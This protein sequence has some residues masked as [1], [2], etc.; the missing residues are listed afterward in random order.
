[1]LLFDAINNV[2]LVC[3]IAGIAMQA[4]VLYLR[5][6]P[7]REIL[8]VIAAITPATFFAATAFTRFLSWD[9]SYIFYDIVNFY[10][11]RLQQWEFGSFRTSI[12]LFGPLFA[13]LQAGMPLTKDVVLVA[14]KA[15][16]WLL[17]VAIITIITDQLH[18]LFFPKIKKCLF[19]G[20]VYTAILSL[21]V[22]GLALKTLNYDLFSMLFGVLGCIWCMAGL[23]PDRKNLLVAAL[24]TLTLAAQEKLIASPLLWVALV[25]TTVR[26]AGASNL[27]L[28]KLV[29]QTG[30][31]A[32]A[33]TAIPMVTIAA[34]FAIVYCTHGPSG[35]A[36]NADQLFISWM[37]CFWPFIRLFGADT[38]PSVVNQSLF[39]ELPGILARTAIVVVSV[40]LL[41]LF[42]TTLQQ[43]FRS[44]KRYRSWA[45]SVASITNYLQLVLLTIITVTGVVAQ[46]ALTVYIWP[47]VPVTTG[48]YVPRMTFNGIAHHFGAGSFLEHTAASMAWSCAVFVNALP[49]IL[50][51]GL[52]AASIVRLRI[53]DRER[54]RRLIP[55]DILSTLF[56]S[57]PAVYGALQIPLYPRYL[58][59][60]LL[61]TIVTMIPG[62]F[63]VPLHHYKRFLPGICAAALLLLGAE[64]APFQP[65]GAAF[66]PIWSNYSKDFHVNPGFGKVTPWYPGWGEELF[67]A[68]QKIATL[69]YNHPDTITLFYNFPAS[70]VRP[71]AHFRLSAMPHGH[72]ILPYGYGN[73]D[74]YILSRNGISSYPYIKFPDKVKP[75]FSL[76]DRGFVKAW[77]F[78][79]SDLKAAGFLF[80]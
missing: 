55:T 34:S 66:R 44:V 40:F 58:N 36:F 73:N 80:R 29:V 79:G 1:M 62:L 67:C 64:L 57:V 7:V 68:F 31:R 6:Q 39:H 72:G 33:V 37:S 23:H 56:L 28:K 70:L 14:A 38:L 8:L 71:P 21:P 63:A 11:A 50:L 47:H 53:R 25:A 54:I 60:F 16:H 22:T 18:T 12:T 48:N 46:Y 41:S 76:A 24:I 15:A 75:L 42:I 74:Y 2:E 3:C 45:G 43:I 20:V 4:G 26:L 27:P 78:R 30:V 49:T 10:T 65:L 51:A 59:I 77:V 52:F 35:P 5:K 69:E 61:G 17:G 9:E 32:V 13:A 19:H